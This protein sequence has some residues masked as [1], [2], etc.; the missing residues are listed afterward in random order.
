MRF[1]LFVSELGQLQSSRMATL[2]KLVWLALSLGITAGSVHAA[3]FGETRAYSGAAQ[4]FQDKAWWLAEANFAQFV[5]KY[6]KSEQRAQAVLYQAVARFHQ[7]NSAGV[8]ELLEANLERAA[9]VADEYQFWIAEAHFQKGD[10]AAAAAAY[11]ELWRR[12]LASARR[13]EALVNEAVS[14]SRLGQWTQVVTRL[15]TPESEFARAAQASPTNIFVARGRLLLGDAQLALKN[16]PGV[17]AAIAPLVGRTLG[18]DLDWR[19]AR[20]QF[21]A[22]LA[23]GRLPEALTTSSNLLTLAGA[24]AENRSELM[25]ESVALQAGVLERLGR[26]GEAKETFKRN[27]SPGIRPERQRQALLRITELAL[28]E[29]HAMEAATNLAGFLQL[30]SNSPA[31]DVALFSLGEIHLKHHVTTL[32]TNAAAGAAPG[33]KNLELALGLFDRLVTTFTNSSYLGKAELNRGWCF[34]MRNQMSESAKAF[35]RATQLLPEAEDVVIARFKLGDAWFVQKDFA[36]ALERYR[37]TA[38]AL[39]RWPRVREALGAELHYQ[40]LRASLE[41]TNV[42]AAEE[43]MAQILKAKP[44]SD[45]ADRSLLLLVQGMAA[46]GKPEL[47]RGEV[48]KFVALAPDSLL[49]PEV[50]VVLGRTREQQADW[51][52]AITGYDEW[53]KRFPTN[54]LRPRVEYQRALSNFK[55]GRETNALAQF[56]NLVAQFPTNDLAPRAQ[57]W[58]ADYYFGQGDFYNAEINYKPIYQIWPTN[59]LAFEARMM[60]GRAAMARPPYHDAITHFTNLTSSLNCPPGL[61]AQAMFAY[62]DA[63]MAQAPTDTNRLANYETAIQVFG[64]ILQTYPTNPIAVLAWGEMAK[65]YKQLGSGSASNAVFCFS[66]VVTSAGAN[67]AARSEAQVGLAGVILEMAPREPREAQTPFIR[68]ALSNLLE[69]VHGTNRREGETPDQFWVKKAGLEAGALFER[70]GEW[71]Q[72]E[73]LYGR[74]QDLLPVLRATMQKKIDQAREQRTAEKSQPGV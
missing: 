25:S 66:Q 48:E 22:Q 23:T 12:Y 37:Q 31:A 19:V 3:A 43:A 52:A 50:E 59:E 10:F 51:P 73:K 42:P 4:A 17:E 45:L 6:P 33:S 8:I 14:L 9:V 53:L 65:C 74:L 30:S 72:A 70:L 34:W 61:K 39:P 63:L 29:G 32:A 27:L 64:T 7:T 41:V 38:E 28:A 69:V 15:G 68:Q 18:S 60:A 20:L 49:R 5:E 24:V 62:G 35:E 40:I 36:R 55:A 13:M 47:A 2:R 44:G 46:S 21:D 67:V 57:W 58:V 16:Y 26:R 56:T 54:A 71:E 1:P 11:R